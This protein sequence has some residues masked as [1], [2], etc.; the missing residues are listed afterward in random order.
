MSHF[1]GVTELKSVE[2][3]NREK[4]LDIT[5]DSNIN[6]I[7]FFPGVISHDSVVVT[8]K[9]GSSKKIYDINEIIAKEKR[10]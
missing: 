4:Y 2:Y 3:F 8:F 10:Q 1:D 7:F 5:L 9:D 6:Q